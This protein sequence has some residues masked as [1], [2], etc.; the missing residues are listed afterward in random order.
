MSMAWI[1]QLLLTSQTSEEETSQGGWMILAPSLHLQCSVGWL[2]AL[3]LW[4]GSLMS[5]AW[6]RGR[7]SSH[8]SQEEEKQEQAGGGHDVPFQST[9]Q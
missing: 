8:G 5:G 1:S 6:H 2:T 7:C 9:S 4:G 3:G